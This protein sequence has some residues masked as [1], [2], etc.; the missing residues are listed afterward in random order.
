MTE[1]YEYEPPQPFNE[2]IKDLQWLEQGRIGTVE[3][4][5][6]FETVFSYVSLW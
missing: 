6:N 5:L 4:A 3:D 1:F 2:L